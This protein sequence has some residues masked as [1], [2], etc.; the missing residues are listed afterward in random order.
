MPFTTRGSKTD[1]GG[2]LHERR[3]CDTNQYS[4]GDS[5]VQ[6]NH[7]RSQG[8]IEGIWNV[9]SNLESGGGGG[10]GGQGMVVHV[11]PVYGAEDV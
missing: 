5:T 10:R 4:R 11:R 9:F 1:G 6:R 3:H 8:S 2:T 7:F